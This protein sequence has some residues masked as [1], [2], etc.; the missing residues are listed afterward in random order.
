MAFK[1][2]NIENL[3]IISAGAEGKAVAKQDSLTIF[4]PFAVPGDIVD[5]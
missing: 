2:Y 4:V 1:R 3:E 5:V